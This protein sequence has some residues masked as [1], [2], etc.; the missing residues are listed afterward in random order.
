MERRH[1]P[2]AAASKRP[3]QEADFEQY[4]NRPEL[5]ALLPVLY[6]GVFPNLA[7]YAKDRADLNAILLTGIP[8]EVDIPGFQNFT[9]S[10]KA[11]MLRLNVAIP[12][13]ANPDRLGLLNGDIQGFPN[14]RRLT[15]DVVTI[16]LR[17][18]AGA[19]L[20]L[21]DNTFTPDGA[22]G[23]I[24]DGTFPPVRQFLNKFPYIGTPYSGYDVPAA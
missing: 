20:P 10:T 2:A 7:A 19:T 1:L 22:A 21:V 16:E 6:P 24:E 4:V 17:A 5:A 8:K 3:H 12:P 9:G 15:D 14:G 11:D 13:A 23:L 18:V